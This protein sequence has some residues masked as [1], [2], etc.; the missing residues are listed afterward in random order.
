MLPHQ[1]GQPI[2]NGDICR[3]VQKGRYFNSRLNYGIGITNNVL[4][5][6]FCEK[7]CEIFHGSFCVFCRSSRSWYI[8]TDVFSSSSVYILITNG[9]PSDIYGFLGVAVQEFTILLGWQGGIIILIQNGA[10]IFELLFFW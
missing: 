3:I 7:Q 8:F 4:Y 6:T 10:Q 5:H 2:E 9:I 1:V